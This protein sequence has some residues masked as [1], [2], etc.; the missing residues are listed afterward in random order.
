MI[1][2]HNLLA[3]FIVYQKEC[4]YVKAVANSKKYSLNDKLMEII[5]IVIRELIL[6]SFQYKKIV[7][8]RKHHDTDLNT[9]SIEIDRHFF[10]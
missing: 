9:S 7:E 6:F 10:C 8:I 2:S 3:A 1:Y 5:N 4:N